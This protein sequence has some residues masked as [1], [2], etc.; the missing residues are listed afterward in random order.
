[1]IEEIPGDLMQWLRGSILSRERKRDTG[2]HCHAAGPAHDHLP[3]QAFGKGTRGHPFR[4]FLGQDEVDPRG[5][6]VL[7][8]VITLFEDVKEIRNT[9]REVHLEYEGKICIVAS[10]AVVD[11]F[12]PRTSLSS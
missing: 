1:M 11:S 2:S 5:R 10:H 7:E 6:N 8:H 9:R 3:D 4:S 12:L